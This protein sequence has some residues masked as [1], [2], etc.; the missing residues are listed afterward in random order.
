MAFSFPSLPAQMFAAGLI[1]FVN[2]WNQV[3]NFTPETG[4]FH[5]LNNAQ[6]MATSFNAGLMIEQLDR[7]LAKSPIIGRFQL[8]LGAPTE[9]RLFFDGQKG[10]Q[11]ERVPGGGT[12]REERCLLLIQATLFIVINNF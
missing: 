3:H 10:A 11:Q 8:S 5:V 4:K 2:R 1:P 7:F 12:I 6:P 9:S